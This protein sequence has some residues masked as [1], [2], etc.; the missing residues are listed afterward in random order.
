MSEDRKNTWIKIYRGIID[1]PVWEDDKRLKAW[2]YILLETTYR[3]RTK[4]Y[5]GQYI[6]LQRGDCFVTIR[7]MSKAIGCVPRTI[8]RILDQFQD[9]GMI[10]YEIVTGMY[11]I[12]KPINYE[13]FQSGKLSDGI[14][15][16][17]TDDIT[18]STTE[19]ITDDTTESI[20]D[21]IAKTPHH[22]KVNKDK[23]ENKKNKNT[24]SPAGAGS[25]IV[26][27]VKGGGDMP[28]GW[29]QKLEDLF[30]ETYEKNSETYPGFCRQIL[31][32][33]GGWDEEE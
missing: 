23:K 26:R 19:S 6:K 9:D 31:Y 15:D 24:P 1:S 22:K 3:A 17:T 30:A 18:K 16:D 27:K 28:D 12:I 8:R 25:A 7:S 10:S 5:R 29:T 14:T 33:V 4:Y 11:A 21:G 32:D 13:A 20:T 2:L